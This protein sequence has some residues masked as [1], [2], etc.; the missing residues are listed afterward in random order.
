LVQIA[1]RCAF[2]AAQF[3]VETYRKWEFAARLMR[4]GSNSAISR[5]GPLERR[6]IAG[7]KPPDYSR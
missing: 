4:N 6:E 1:V 2:A 5:T 3:E 7:A